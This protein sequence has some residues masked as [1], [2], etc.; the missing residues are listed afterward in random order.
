MVKM[1]NRKQ[2]WIEYLQCQN[3][4]HNI[5]NGYVTLYF[6]ITSY[7]TLVTFTLLIIFFCHD[8][9]E[10]AIQNIYKCIIR[11]KRL[12]TSQRISNFF[13]TVRLFRP[14]VSNLLAKCAKFLLKNFEWAAFDQQLLWC[15]LKVDLDLVCLCKSLDVQTNM[16]NC[17]KKC[18][19]GLIY[20][21]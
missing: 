4:D 14:G 5:L 2:K 1:V 7:I 19:T 15:F 10:Q 17:A 16:S 11:S 21:I 9:V 18:W 12:Q 20:T 6:L 8:R 3:W 13:L